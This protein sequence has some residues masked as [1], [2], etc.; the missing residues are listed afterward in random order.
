MWSAPQT[1]QPVASRYI[2]W[3]IPVDYGVSVIKHKSH[4]KKDRPAKEWR[5]NQEATDTLQFN[6]IL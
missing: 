3:A 6:R 1:V 4:R 5:K 2:D